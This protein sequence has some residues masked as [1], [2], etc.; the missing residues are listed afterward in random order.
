MSLLFNSYEYFS[1]IL[2]SISVRNISNIGDNTVIKITCNGPFLDVANINSTENVT[3]SLFAVDPLGESTR[4]EE[5]AV[6]E[7]TRDHLVTE[8]LY[9]IEMENSFGVGRC[10]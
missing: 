4:V 2:T 10:V 1:L 9:W 8:S 3:L 7:V 5:P 6:Y